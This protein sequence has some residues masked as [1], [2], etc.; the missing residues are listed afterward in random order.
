VGP[1][2]LDRLGLGYLVLCAG[3]RENPGGKN[4][5]MT[6]PANRGYQSVFGPSEGIFPIEIPARQGKIL[7]IREFHVVS[8]HVLFLKV[9]ELR[10]N[11]L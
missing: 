11:S 9:M 2:G 5:V 10:I 1:I 6:G 4:E 7:T 8:K 3:T